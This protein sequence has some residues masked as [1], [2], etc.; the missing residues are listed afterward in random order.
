MNTTTTV[1]ENRNSGQIIWDT[2]QSLHQQ[3]QV[4]TRELLTKLTGLK[5]TI[6]DDHVSR[7]IENGRMCR[8]RPG[9]FAL[10]EAIP[11]PRSVSITS[12]SHG[13]CKVEVGDELMLLWPWERR[14]LAK[15]LAGDAVQYSNIQ[16]GVAAGTLAVD[17][18]A[19]LMAMKRGMAAEMQ[20][21]RRQLAARDAPVAPS[22]QMN[23][24]GGP[25]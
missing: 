11:E 14:E 6:V 20:D 18:A 12:L 10:V 21:L 4:I 15:L 2:I 16:A 17:L 5:M 9:V 1:E 19:D 3:G 8:L 7:M 25:G 24:L 23:L 22:P 13:L